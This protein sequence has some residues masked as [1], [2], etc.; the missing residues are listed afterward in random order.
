MWTM[1]TLTVVGVNP[2]TRP[3]DRHLCP[4]KHKRASMKKEKIDQLRLN[5]HDYAQVIGNFCVELFHF[6]ALFAIGGITVWAGVATGLEAY[7]DRKSTRLN[8]SH[9]A[10]SYA[11]FCLKKKRVTE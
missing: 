7:T 2:G 11:V 8:S 4:I 9:V 10:I 1:G 6:F 3:Y 5:F